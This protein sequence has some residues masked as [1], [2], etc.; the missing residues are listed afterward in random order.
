MGETDLFK[1]HLYLI[2]LCAKEETL[3]KQVN[4]NVKGELKLVKTLFMLWMAFTFGLIP[5][6]MV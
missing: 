6:G 1:N 2:G 4:K 3:K 5:L